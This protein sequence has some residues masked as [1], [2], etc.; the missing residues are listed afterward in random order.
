M[1]EV[2][3]ADPTSLLGMIHTMLHSH[4]QSALLLLFPSS[5]ALN[6]QRLGY[7]AVGLL[8]AFPPVLHTL[9]VLGLALRITMMG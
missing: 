7:S 2:C 4:L 6:S 3:S 8:K 5:C 1:V 9:E